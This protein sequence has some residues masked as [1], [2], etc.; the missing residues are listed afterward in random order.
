MGYM[1]IMD[2][3]VFNGV[4]LKKLL[5]DFF[6]EFKLYYIWVLVWVKYENIILLWNIK[7]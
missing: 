5:I 3:W 4:L 6:I 7:F 1:L 2:F